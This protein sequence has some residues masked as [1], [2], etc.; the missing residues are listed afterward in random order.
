MRIMN[1]KA[2]TINGL[3]Q[4]MLGIAGVAIVLAVVLIVLSTLSTNTD[5]TTDA[6]L[7]GNPFSPL[8]NATT[9][10]CQWKNSSCPSQYAP[11]YNGSTGGCQWN[12]S[13][14][15]NYT[16]LTQNITGA[17]HSNSTTALQSVIVSVAGIPTWVSIVIVIALAF[18]V[19]GFFYTR[20]QGGM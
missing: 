7:C 8:F 6:T 15:T 14:I 16:G 17:T 20:N 2:Q 11:F 3:Q 5:N 1:K 19:L 10:S 13:I 18:L 9:G 12:S 4:F